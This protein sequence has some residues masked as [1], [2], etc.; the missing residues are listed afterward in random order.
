MAAST[1]SQCGALEALDEL[2]IAGSGLGGC[3]FF[4]L[5]RESLRVPTCA[6]IIVPQANARRGADARRIGR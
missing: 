1:A 6:P 4:A 2:Q 3:A 5:R